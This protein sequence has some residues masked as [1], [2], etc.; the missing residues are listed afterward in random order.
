MGSATREFVLS[1]ALVLWMQSQQDNDA[2]S[3]FVGGERDPFYQ[4]VLTGTD[5]ASDPEGHKS[6]VS[7]LIWRE[8]AD[9][10]K[11]TRSS[12]IPTNHCILQP[13]PEIVLAIDGCSPRR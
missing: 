13:C 9:T 6:G 2:M 12:R 10:S 1:P 5:L 3:Q 4:R 11:M 8:T 7:L